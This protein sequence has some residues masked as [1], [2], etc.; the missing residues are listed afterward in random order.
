MILYAFF[1]VGTAIVCLY[2][3]HPKHWSFVLPSEKGKRS[4]T[5]RERVFPFAPN[6]S[7]IPTDA[8]RA[9]FVSLN[10]SFC[11]FFSY[12]LVSDTRIFLRNPP[13]S[14]HRSL[15]PSRPSPY[16]CV[17]CW[18]SCPKKQA[19][20]RIVWVK[21]L[22]NIL[23]LSSFS[24]NTQYTKIIKRFLFHS[25]VEFNSSSGHRTNAAV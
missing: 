6:S 1:L 13:C 14:V 23:T 21:P 4:S 7:T 20:V 5:Y 3:I 16:V 15:V 12:F 25:R 9:A 17:M 18:G 24:R 10:F 8:A 2:L 22:Y 19:Q 11:V